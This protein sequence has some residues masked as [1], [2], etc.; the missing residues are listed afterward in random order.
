MRREKMLLSRRVAVAGPLFVATVWFVS[1]S[2]QRDQGAAFAHAY[3]M[4]ERTAP[5]RTVGEVAPPPLPR[6]HGNARLVG[7]IVVARHPDASLAVVH[8]GS[9]SHLLRVGQSLGD[10]RLLALRPS[11]AHFRERSGSRGKTANQPRIAH[12]AIDP[13]QATT[14]GGRLSMRTRVAMCNQSELR[15]RVDQEPAAASVKLQVQPSRG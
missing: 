8:S 1:S 15:P 2:G 3:P 9:A 12:V 13:M 6:C 14:H 11:E 7:S 5:M 4:N 10:S